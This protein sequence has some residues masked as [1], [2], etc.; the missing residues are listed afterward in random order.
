MRDAPSFLVCGLLLG[1]AAAGHPPPPRQAG[2]RITIL[3]DA[4]G[5]DPAM[6][7]D[8]G[9]AALVEVGGRRILFDTGDDPAAFAGNV[10]AAGVDLRDLDLV[11]MSHRHGDHMGGLSHLLSVNPG[12]RIF[13]PKEAFGVYGGSLPGSFYRRD[14][15]LPAEL[16]YFGGQP[17]EVMH[18]GSAWPGARFELIDKTTQ[19]APGVWLVALV[20][21]APGTKELKELSL[22]VDTPQGIVLVVGCSHPGIEAIVAAA[23][24]AV[25][26]RVR[27]VVGG[28]HLVVAQ[29]DAIARVVAALRGGPVD[30]VAPGHCTGEPTFAA[31]RTAF[32][33]RYLYA[34]VGTVLSLSAGAASAA[35][36]GPDATLAGEEL[37]ADRRLARGHADPAEEDRPAVAR[38]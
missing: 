3:Y 36:R 10:R 15:S 35:A 2:D 34:G 19:V 4:F 14:P 1:C 17:P 33:D 38:R 12:V 22:A 9:F 6:R 16:R 25:P 11:V 29:D 24:E 37:A 21:D 5:R 27:V 26:K 18:F 20:S 31:L 7:K 32:G 23:V 8:W 13:A 28:M 30:A